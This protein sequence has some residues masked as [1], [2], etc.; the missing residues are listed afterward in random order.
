GGIK[1]VIWTDV[2][3]FLIIIIG[4][5]ITL[6]MGCSRVGGFANMWNLC[7]RGGRIQ[8]IDF[9][10]NPLT[11]HTFWGLTIGVGATCTHLYG[12]SQPGV[13]RFSATRSL[14]DAR[15]TMLTVIPAVCVIYALTALVGLTV[16]AYYS[17]IQCDPMVIGAVT[18]I[19]QIFPYFVMDVLAV[20]G[21]P[22]IFL[23]A[24]FSAALSTISSLVNSLAANVW[25]DVLR[26][27]FPNTS[28]A[29]ATH[30]TKGLVIVL[31]I[32][33]TVMAFIAM[34]IPG[35]ILQV[36]MALSGAVGGS[37]V[38]MYCLGAFTTSCNWKGVTVG[39]WV[40]FAFL[41]WIAL[42]AFT[43]KSTKHILPP[44]STNGCYVENVSE[45]FNETITT[46]YS[47][48]E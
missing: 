19:N 31:G 43:I 8:P 24:M 17:H 20:P 42:G 46:P 13:Q 38:G 33:S 39:G 48:N 47:T 11:R 12:V 29:R 35:Q 37:V 21:V 15:L 36:T 16:Y 26:D 1:A 27:R 25:E 18:N 7:Q 34:K 14:K 23:A 6:A 40:G 10:L 30:I 44:A 3:Q 5:I 45:L 4:M 22:G 32:L 41:L 9:D 28:P 2:F